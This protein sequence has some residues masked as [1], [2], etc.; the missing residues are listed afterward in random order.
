ML[1]YVFDTEQLAVDA[2]NYIDNV[3]G[4][5]IIGVNA[6]TGQSEPNAAKTERWA[7][8]KQRLDGKWVFPYVGD[9]LVAQY[10]EDVVN[11]FRDNFPH[12][13]EEYDESWF[14]QYDESN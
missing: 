11:Y 10:P 14:P 3:G 13:K 9:E 4:V 12:V 1:Y 5:P 8:P 6:A 2:E 7:I